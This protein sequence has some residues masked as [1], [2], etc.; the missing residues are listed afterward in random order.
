MTAPG[1]GRHDETVDVVVIGAGF[2]GIYAL[3]RLATSGRRVVGVE[4]AD[5]VGGTWY[6]NCYPGA[7]VDVEAPQYGYSFS[8]ELDQRWDWTEIQPTQGEVERYLNDVADHLD[9]RRHVH[10]STRVTAATWDDEDGSW[11]V[12]TDR[13]DRWHATHVVAAT[14]NLSEP[15]APDLPGRDSFAGTTLFTARFPRDGFDFTGLRVGVFGTGSSGVQTIPVVAREARHLHVFQ[16]SPAYTRPANNRAIDADEMATIRAGYADLRRR[17]RA[18][19]GGVLHFGG[20]P[21]GFGTFPS[22]SVD[23]ATTILDASPEMRRRRLEELAWN[24]PW[25]WPDV[26]TDLDANQL[27]VE[28]YA[29]LVRTAVSDPELAAALTPRYPIGCKRPILDTGYFDT[30]NRDDVT[31]VDLRANPIERI[32]PAG[33]QTRGGHVEL[34]VMVFATGFDAVSGALCRIDVRGRDGDVLAERWAD[35]PGA[36][37]GLQVAGFPNLFT[38]TGPG[39]PAALANV[40]MAIEHHVDWIVDCL[41]HLRDCGARTIE[42]TDTA[43]REWME[44]VST[45]AS[46]S[47]MT[48][49]SC[50]SWYLGENVPGKARTFPL[51]AG[52]YPRYREEADAVAD[53]GY[54][55]FEIDGRCATLPARA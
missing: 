55:G 6:W 5:G 29:E 28:Q 14:G 13:G 47:V 42:A 48:S 39:S 9:V 1:R 36:L 26:T 24:A 18:S 16:R 17:M 53:D 7:R 20:F 51:Y 8:P 3:H 41:D 38:V 33:V 22:D 50:H 19:G 52:G 12:E 37:L 31:L 49:P 30:F 21:S 54:P 27:A 11:L 15:I 40:V 4:A 35:G 46:R 45:L 23:P 25:S 44:H 34:D 32:T 10:F 2:A 43:Q